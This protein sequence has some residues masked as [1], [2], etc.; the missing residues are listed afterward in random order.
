[1][2][3]IRYVVAALSIAVVFASASCTNAPTNVDPDFPF[4][5][6]FDGGGGFG[7]G[8]RTD[9]VPKIESATVEGTTAADTAGR[10]GGGFGSGN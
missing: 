8:N 4:G 3:K 9:T 1:M 6:S 10:G 2:R 7:S 5:P